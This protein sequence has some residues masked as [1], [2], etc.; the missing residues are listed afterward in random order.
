MNRLRTLRARFALWTAGLFLL[1]LSAFGAYIYTSV[2]NGLLA[3]MDASLKLDGSRVVDALEPAENG[4]YLLLDGF[5]Q[6]PETT[7]WLQ[8][9]FTIRVFS[10]AGKNLQELGAYRSARIP[11]DSLAALPSTATVDDPDAKTTLRVYT[12]TLVENSRHLATVQV[13]QSLQPAQETLRRLLATLLVSVPLLVGLT[14]LSGYVLA[15]RALAPIDRIT[16]TAQRISA[17]D[18]SARLDLPATDDEVGR[19]ART[20]DAMLQRLDLSFKRERQFT[21]DASHELRTPL[22]AMQ[23]IL[24]M[25][26]AKRRSPEDYEQALDDLGE[27]AERLRTL[28]ENLL[29]L[30]QT[31]TGTTHHVV[32]LSTLLTDVADSL[33]PLAEAKSLELVTAVADGLTVS[34]DSDNLVRLFVNLLD[35]AI[36][37]TDSGRIVVAADRNNCNITKVSVSDSGIGISAEHLPRIF[38]RFYRVDPSRTLPGAGLGL[39]IAR[40]IAEAH[41][42][43]LEAHSTPGTGSTFVVCLPSQSSRPARATTP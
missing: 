33:R 39:A 27:E 22:A 38:D 15:G 1:V 35:N 14:G 34:G 36:K 32:D 9:G 31:D 11:L 18:L 7:A 16:R 26:R 24:G 8:P 20:F 10:P 21:A 28:S 29:R 4:T 41:G 30:E 17:E 37:Y 42:G 23:A 13:A 43:T 6:L 3:E 2:A 25:I 12:L 19:L 40:S 5:M